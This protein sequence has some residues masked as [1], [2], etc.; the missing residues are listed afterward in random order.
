MFNT[1]ILLLV[2]NRPSTT[3]LV[4]DAIKA[5][6]PRKLFIAA[7]GPRE[8]RK[9]EIDLCQKVRDLVVDNIDWDCEVNTLFREKNLGCGRGVSEAISWFFKNV[10][11]GIIL[12]DDTLPNISFFN[13][14][15]VLLERYRCNESIM[16]ISGNNF[17]SGIIRSDGDYYY[18]KY[19]HIWGWATWKRAWQKY[20]FLLVN[21]TEFKVL[22]LNEICNNDEN[23]VNYWKKIFDDVII[24]KIDTWDYQW[25]F[26][27][28]FN[29]ASCILPN[30]N[31]VS[32]IGFGEYA[33]HTLDS[34]SFLSKMNSYELSS[35]RRPSL[36]SL[37]ADYF[38][39]YNIIYPS[40]SEEN[41]KKS[42]LE[43]E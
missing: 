40:K 8:N 16:H 7:D 33:T 24:G 2:F 42:L 37:E 14:C 35:F 29:Q 36:Y 11:E 23:Q 6:K 20:D 38:T 34:N 19:S 5:V 22:G 12:E 4:F 15:A 41:R 30:V 21:W 13:Y 3:K 43:E 27:V 32:N 28:W 18:S 26:A 17:Q 1:P 10:D 39:F 25:M 31:L 9:G